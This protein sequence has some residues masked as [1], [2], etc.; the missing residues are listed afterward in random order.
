MNCIIFF[1]I[2]CC[3]SFSFSLLAQVKKMVLTYD[4]KAERRERREREKKQRIGS[5]QKVVA[6]ERAA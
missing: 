1:I 5:K 4:W 3:F 6:S 2:C